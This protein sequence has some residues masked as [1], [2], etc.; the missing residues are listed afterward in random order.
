M[1][2]YINKSYQVLSILFFVGIVVF[3]IGSLSIMTDLY[4]LSDYQSYLKP[5]ALTLY[6]KASELNKNMFDVATFL[7][8]ISSFVMFFKL[9]RKQ[10]NM[11]SFI[12]LMIIVTLAAILLGYYVFQTYQ[13]F[14]LYH[15]TDISWSSNANQELL[16][17]TEPGDFWLVYATGSTV[18]GFIISLIYLPIT[19]IKF[20]KTRRN[21][22]EVLV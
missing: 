1:N 8:V 7:V 14:N 3:F 6:N 9:Y 16:R 12:Y 5:E 15:S 17:Y 4:I 19:I 22:V 2:K 18:F 13:L 10:I 21:N 20:L 11:V